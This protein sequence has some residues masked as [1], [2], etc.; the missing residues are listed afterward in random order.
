MSTDQRNL[1]VENIVQ[2]V[3]AGSLSAEGVTAQALTS[4]ENIDGEV[5]AFTD[6]TAERALTEARAVDLALT[7]GKNLPLAGVPYAVKN[8]FDIEGTTT[9]AGS[10]INRENPPAIAD[11]ALIS[12]LKSAGAVLVGGLNMGEFAYDFTGENVHD[13]NCKNPHDLTRMTGGSSSGSGGSVASGMVPVSLG[14]DTN[15]SIR[16]PSSFCGLFGLKPTFG[17]LSRAGT[18]PFVGDLD[19]LGPIARSAKDLALFFDVMQGIDP[20]DPAQVDKPVLATTPELSKR[21][22]GLRVA[23]AGGYFRQ[24]CMPE[25]LLAVDLVAATL[26]ATVEIDIPEAARARASAYVITTSQSAELHLDRLRNRAE[27]F[28]PDTR[29]RFLSGAMVPAVWTQKAQRFRSWFQTAMREIFK[30]TDILLAPATPC[31]AI[32]SETKTIILDGEELPARANI[33]LFTQPISFIGLPVVVAPV[34]LDGA[35]LPIGVQVIAPAWREDLALRVAH[36]LQ[37]KGVS[38]AP[39]ANIK[40]QAIS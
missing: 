2:S 31:H 12:R 28:D 4:I 19:H 25:A 36:D 6:V 26:G 24:K 29:D 23:I 1:T 27:D 3:K 30:H 10:K 22:D 9:R 20:K 40:Q 8:L 34:W 21:A 14:S 33:G 15:G 11:A 17:R 5:N 39:V 16:V 32:P 18:Y 37:E 35:K 7:E 38:S 13:G